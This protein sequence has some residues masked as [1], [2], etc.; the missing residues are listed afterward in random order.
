MKLTCDSMRALPKFLYYQFSGPELQ[1][2]I[3]DSAIGSSVPGFNLGLLSSIT[4]PVPPLDEQHA[5]AEAL[6][7]VDTLL[8]GLD[9]LIEKKRAVKQA[10][11][12]QLLSG[13]RRLTDNEET[14]P[15]EELGSLVTIRM[16]RTPSRADAKNWGAGWPWV[17]ISDLN[18]RFIVTTKEQIT[19]RA[20]EFMP[21]VPPGTLLLSFKLSVGKVGIASVPCYTNEAIAALYPHGIDRLFLYYALLSVDWSAYGVQA[22][23][24]T[25]LNLASLAS[26]TV[27]VPPLPEQQAIAEV[28]TALD[29][30][31]RALDERRAKTQHLKRGMMA[32]LLSGKVRLR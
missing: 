11:M 31:L 25:T 23:K 10:V 20:A 30:E 21:L 29:D 28:L 9:Q 3:T 7:D 4:V 19:D 8:L 2:I 24:G 5:I 1:R 27:P 26:V 12:A 32:S 15:T 22:V 18:H 16:G 13:E 6:G 14:W 17:A